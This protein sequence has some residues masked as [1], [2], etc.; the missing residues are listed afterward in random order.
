MTDDTIGASYPATVPSAL[1]EV[2]EQLDL[3]QGLRRELQRYPEETGTILVETAEY[4]LHEGD[5]EQGLRLLVALRDHPPT[6]EDAQYALIEIARDLREHGDPAESERMVEDLMKSA[7]LRPGPAGLLADLFEG[8]GDPVRA[9][10]C[11]NIAAR[12]FLDRPGES[13]AGASVF[14]IGPL[15]GRARLRGDAGLEPDVHDLVVMEA[16]G[17]FWRERSEQGTDTPGVFHSR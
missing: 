2:L 11:Y 12:E 13:L 7:D 4:L 16:A 15:V 10:H 3:R 9:L 17:R 6:P 8:D 5:R 1:A 14:D